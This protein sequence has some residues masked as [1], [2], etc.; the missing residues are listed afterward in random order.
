LLTSGAERCWGANYY[1]QLG[2]GGTTTQSTPVGVVG[3]TTGARIAAGNGHTCSILTS[4]IAKC[5]GYGY[6]GQLGDGKATTSST[7][8]QVVNY[9]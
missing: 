5:W 6:S 7:P 9:P 3:I 1:G 4:G 2:N 8:V